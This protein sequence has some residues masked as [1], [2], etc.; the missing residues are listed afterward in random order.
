MTRAAVICAV[1]VVAVNAQSSFRTDA[2][3]AEGAVSYLLLDAA[4]GKVL[5]IR[6]RSAEV[7]VPVGSLVKPFL[8]ITYGQTH[9]MRFPIHD[10]TG[11]DCW[12]MTGHGRIGMASAIAYSCN[13]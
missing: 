2:P 13:S 8:A 6:W 10:C 3:S 4:H 1:A 12:L 9:R 11:E 7:A 5:A